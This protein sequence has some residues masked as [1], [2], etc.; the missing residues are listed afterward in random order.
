MTKGEIKCLVDYMQKVAKAIPA[1]LSGLKD[2]VTLSAFEL[3]CYALQGVKIS[4]YDKALK[5]AV[6]IPRVDDLND[7][8]LTFWMLNDR[9]HLQ[10]LP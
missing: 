9:E 6:T 8:T 3:N 4:T 5:F 2:A 10:Y 1:G 7:D